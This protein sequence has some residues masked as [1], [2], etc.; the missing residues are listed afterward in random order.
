MNM[1][2]KGLLILV[3][4]GVVILGIAFYWYGYR[5]S[6]IKKECYNTARK[7]AIETSNLQDGKF[8]IEIYDGYYKLC[9]DQKGL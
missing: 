6:Q 3:I 8:E 2:N 1:K 4:L 5:P 7:K 9:L